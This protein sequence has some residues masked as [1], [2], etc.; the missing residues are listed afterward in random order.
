MLLA[1][2]AA[3]I[4]AGKFPVK[5]ILNIKASINR[6]SGILIFSKILI[7]NQLW[8]CTN[9]RQNHLICRVLALSSS[10]AAFFSGVM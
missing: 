4:F 2:V 9:S 3:I 10:N 7:K 1:N 5:G 6:I 8:T